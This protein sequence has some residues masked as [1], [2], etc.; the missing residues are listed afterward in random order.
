MSASDDRRAFW[1]RRAG[2]VLTSEDARESD[3]NLAGFFRVLREWEEAARAS[4]PP[5]AG[6]DRMD[7]R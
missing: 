5:P 6:S 1:S 7:R 4:A 3:A 2:R